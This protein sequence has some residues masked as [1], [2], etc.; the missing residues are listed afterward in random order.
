MSAGGGDVAIVGGGVLGLTL[1]LRLAQRGHQ[2]TVLEA[3]S[4]VGGLATADAIG[5]IRWDRFYHVIL[6]ADTRLLALL[7]ELKASCW[8]V[9]RPS[10]LALPYTS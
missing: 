7:S 8:K 2:V 3:E 9:N 5:H 6:G 1:G 4:Q 10:A